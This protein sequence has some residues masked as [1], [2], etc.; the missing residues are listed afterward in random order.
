MK[1]L[2]NM[3]IAKRLLASFLLVSII[4]AIIGGIGIFGISSLKAS[5]S[6]MYERRLVSM[7]YI[8]NVTN[9]IANIQ[10]ATRDALLN[11]DKPDIFSSDKQAFEKYDKKYKEN[12]AQLIATINDNSWKEKLESAQQTYEQDFALQ[13]KQVFEKAQSDETAAMASLDQSHTAHNDLANLYTEFLDYRLST[14][15][16]QN[17]ADNNMALLLTILA[18]SATIIGFGISILL[19]I[20]ISRSIGKPVAELAYVAKEFSE[21]GKLDLAI[22]YRSN[23]ELGQLSE[24]FRSVFQQLKT[25]IREVSENLTDVSR[26][27][28][29]LEPLQVYKGDFAPISVAM[30]HIVDELNDTFTIIK[31]SAE[32]V[33]SGSSQISNGAQEL[34]QGS[35]EQASAVEELSASISEIAEK[36]HEN[37]A[38]VINVSENME[39]VAIE[40]ENSNRQMQQMVNAMN[41]IHLSSSEISKIN[42]V[43]DDIAFQTNILA[44]N[45]AV[46]AARAGSAGKGFAVVADEVRNL[47]SKSAD[48]AKQTTQLIEASIQKVNDGTVIADST[49]KA[50]E[51]VTEKM[52]KV[53]QTVEKIKQASLA[54]SDAVAQINQGIEQV[55]SVV[56]TNSATA[57]ESA[58]ASEELSAQ[59]EML[60]NQVSGFQLR[61]R[62]ARQE[63]CESMA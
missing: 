3:K 52:E 22:E 45:A 24:S 35:T 44:L 58:A 21:S 14:A 6:D 27:N 8:I 23:N 47:A 49:A 9:S 4:A 29:N 34:A 36:I 7:K 57:E 53:G 37:S 33:D 60:Y 13:I 18:V 15:A 2:E 56:Q 28:L 62:S 61:N 43:I 20:R 55:S 1:K 31:T 40:V 39:E 42:K 38:N 5:E 12:S 63:D 11:K 51:S 46:E 59:A 48:A 54:Q 19:G 50:L 41:D 17:T 10:A 32:Q 25:I 16:N 26:G 30:N